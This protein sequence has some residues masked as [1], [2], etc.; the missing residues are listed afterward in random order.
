MNV[1]AD[2][3]WRILRDFVGQFL[4]GIGGGLMAS[5]LDAD[6]AFEIV[7]H[8][9]FGLDDP[10]NNP[11]DESNV[12][13]FHNNLNK[14]HWLTFANL[15]KMNQHLFIPLLTVSPNDW[16][17]EEA[18]EEWHWLIKRLDALAN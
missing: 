14:D 2:T 6:N 11:F 15:L 12:T 1:S 3:H 17:R 9:G 13:P 10:L 18:I 8:I 16:T 7:N 5:G 4:T